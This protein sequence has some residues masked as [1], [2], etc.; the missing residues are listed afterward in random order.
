LVGAAATAGFAMS[1]RAR[2]KSTGKVDFAVPG[3]DAVQAHLFIAE[4]SGL[5]KK[6]GLDATIIN[7][8][9]GA[10]TAQMLTAGQAAFAVSGTIDPIRLTLAG[11]DAKIIAGFDS[12]ISYANLLIHKDNRDKYKTVADLAGQSVVVTQPQTPTWLMA[13]YLVDTAKVSDTVTLRA[14][15][16]FVSMLAMLK[17][18]QVAASIATVSMMDAAISEGWGQA[19]FDV[20]DKDAWDKAF[21]GTVTGVSCWTLAKTIEG[22]R[23]DTLAVVEAFKEAQALSLSASAAE[24][25]DMIYDPYLR[26]LPREVAI[27]NIQ[28]YKDRFWAASNLVS[29]SSY[30][31]M[32]G[33]MGGGRMYTD[34]QLRAQATYNAL[35]DMS[36]VGQK[37]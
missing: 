5:F 20:T 8:Q 27:R 34:D 23:E 14:G 22:R 21:G 26:S 1:T 16:D 36:F 18:K 31:K 33:I 7:S 2:A 30:E 32:I 4:K 35:V 17:S 12:R 11:K 13:K 28:I 15:G 25:A 6:Q 3:F 24:I 29:E 10:R 19:L 37:S 9:S